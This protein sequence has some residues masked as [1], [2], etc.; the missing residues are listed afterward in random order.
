MLTLD[1]L[2]ESIAKKGAI[3]D[4][5]RFLYRLSGTAK[6]A[7]A[8][9]ESSSVP[10]PASKRNILSMA[11]NSIKSN[12]RRLNFQTNEGPNKANASIISEMSRTDPPIHENMENLI[13]DQYMNASVNKDKSMFKMPAPVVTP[14]AEKA[15]PKH[16]NYVPINPSEDSMDFEDSSA[17]S[18]TET[19]YN[20]LENK[21]VFIHGFDEES[22]AALVHDCELGGATVIADSNYKHMVDYMILAIDI[23]SMEGIT[24]RAR[25]IV[26]HHWLVSV[27]VILF[28]IGDTFHHVFLFISVERQEV[29]QTNRGPVLFQTDLFQR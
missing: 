26:N 18:N 11:G 7:D 17:M 25:N 28:Q 24:V 3:M 1:W 19:D 12:P 14:P 27:I 21:V 4:Y 6:S 8:A 9:D 13:L 20:F 29:K 23:L 22:H 16:N 10:S 2:V 15:A 5:E